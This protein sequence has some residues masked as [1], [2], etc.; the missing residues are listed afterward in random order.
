MNDRPLHILVGADT[1]ANPNSGAAGTVYATNNAL[2]ELGHDVEA[3]WGDDLPHRIRH[4]NLHYLLELPRAYRNVVRARCELREPDVIQLSQ[5]YAWLAAQEHRRRRRRGIFVNRSHGLESLQDAALAT[6]TGRLGAP[7][8]SKPRSWVSARLRSAL[9]SHIDRVVRYSDGLI[10]PAEEIREHLVQAHG[11]ARDRIEVIHHG[12][13]DVFIDRP[14]PP[15]SAERVKRVLN[16]GQYSTVKGPALIVDAV[17]QALALDRELTF[18]WVCASEDH[19]R[20]RALF[21]PEFHP[22]VQLRAWA[23]QTSLLEIIDSHGIFVAHSI[24]E[25][26]AKA[27]TE[28]MARGLAVV[29]SAVGALKDHARQGDVIRLVEIGDVAAMAEQICALAANPEDAA[30]VGLGAADVAANL[31]WRHCAEQSV[32]FYRTLSQK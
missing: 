26:A 6:W 23:D 10:V 20:V 24:Y 3:I 14:R 7:A 16:I 4:W 13:P 31:R 8:Q 2:R 30:R 19:P 27:C 5:P 28:A 18:T 17:Q 12:V 1:P 9:H 22:R 29:S 15:L 11:A 21:R 32:S 25:G